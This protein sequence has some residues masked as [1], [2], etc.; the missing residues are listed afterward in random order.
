ML[1]KIYFNLDTGYKW[2]IGIEKEKL[3]VFNTEITEIMTRLGWDKVI[4]A[5]HMS[6]MECFKN[7]YEKAYCHPMETVITVEETELINIL[8]E[9]SNAICFNL[10]EYKTVEVTEDDIQTYDRIYRN[11]I[12]KITQEQ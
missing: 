11:K 4:P 3:E 5:K 6:S 8:E 1:K 12:R 10:K 2:G 7:E 9:F